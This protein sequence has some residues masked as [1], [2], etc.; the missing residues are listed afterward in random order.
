MSS[1]PFADAAAAAAT[2][3]FQLSIPEYQAFLDFMCP[4]YQQKGV[5]P[6]WGSDPAMCSRCACCHH[7]GLTLVACLCSASLLQLPSCYC[8][9]L[10]LSAKGCQCASIV[11]SRQVSSHQWAVSQPCC[12]MCAQ[13][14]LKALPHLLQQLPCAG[15]SLEHMTTMTSDGTMEMQ[16][17]SYCCV[18]YLCVVTVLTAVMRVLAVSYSSASMHATRISPWCPCSFSVA[19]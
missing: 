17:N 15:P 12:G 7:F 13:L 19:C 18:C 2:A 6:P 4:G 8:T 14:V 5:F 1:R 9:E 16:G 10:A 3:N 11:T